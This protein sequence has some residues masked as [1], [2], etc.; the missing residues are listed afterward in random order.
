MKRVR[1]SFFPPIALD[2]RA[3]HPLYRQIYDWFQ[4]A[5]LEGRLKP[6]QRVPSTRSLAQ[7]L[8]LSRIPVITAYEQLHAE[9]YLETFKGAGTAV[10]AALPRDAFTPPKPVAAPRAE[11]PRASRRLNQTMALP[12]DLN[13]E[14]L[15]IFR[16][17]L[18]ALD[19][20]PTDIWASL[21]ARHARNPCRLAMAYGG[22][23]GYLPFREAIAEYLGAARGVRCD[24]SQVM[25]VSGSQHGLST[26]AHALLDAGDTVWME[27]PG[28]PGAQRAFMMAD[29]KPVPVPVDQDGLNVEEGMRRAP[30][31][32]AAYITPSHQY[33]LGTAMSAARRMTL[34]NWAA[35][36]RA[37]VIEDDY[38]SEYRFGSRPLG[39]VQGM[40][41]GDRVIY[42]GTFSKVLFPSLRVGYLVL[43]KELVPL[44]SAARDA[45]DLFPSVLF[46]KALTDFIREGHFARHI[47]R[48]RM[49]YMSRRNLL[50]EALSSALG[51]NGEILS[52]EAGMHLV[53][54]LPDGVNDRQ[55]CA[56]AVEAGISLIPLSTC[57][58]GKANR[59][60]L[61]M[62]YGGTEAKDI[63][64]GVLRLA[65]ILKNVPAK[66]TTKVKIRRRGQSR[67][68][69]IA[70]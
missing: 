16:L 33:P 40:G 25:V 26:I 69:S 37:W 35:K 14:T 5:I 45:L 23:M 55:V 64:V 22:P 51:R 56:K 59:P 70:A 24:A 18:P 31:A 67:R 65:Q 53:C 11:K 2:M 9:G 57:Y 38:D 8:K 62:G 20:F 39:A 52:A 17:S 29:L 63:E 36:R 30:H 21:V 50:V 44:F 13:A 34:L 15:G 12:P 10:A 28:Y 43:P 58:L 66:A 6:G 61:V 4:Q 3:E 41:N 19:R 49:L 27:E 42:V 7:E 48:M 54:L 46:Q 47:R 1:G 32:R 60:G 68:A